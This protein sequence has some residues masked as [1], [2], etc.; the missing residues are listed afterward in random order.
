MPWVAQRSDRKNYQP[1]RQRSF[2]MPTSTH[3]TNSRV[4]DSSVDNVWKQ[5]WPRQ[6]V[7]IHVGARFLFHFDGK[8]K[9][10][11]AY[12]LVDSKI[13]LQMGSWGWEDGN[14]WWQVCWP[15]AV[16]ARN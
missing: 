1:L 12:A 3:V 7:G 9:T 5:V 13:W 8:P 16:L 14:P 11:W 2:V 10:P 15:G 4:V 6:V